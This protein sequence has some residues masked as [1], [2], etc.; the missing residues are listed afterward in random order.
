MVSLA[1][2]ELQTYVEKTT[3]A[4]LPIETAP[5]DAYPVTIYVGRSPSTDAMDLDD[6]D[7]D[8]GAFRS[9]IGPDFLVLF[10]RD[11]DY[12]P[13]E[14]WPQGGRSGW[15][16]AHEQWREITG[17]LWNTPMHD[18]RRFNA[19]LGIWIFDRGGSLNAVNEF[20]RSLGVRWYMPG[21]LGEVV[22]ETASIALPDIDET[23]RPD[24]PI[25]HWIHGAQFNRRPPEIILHERRQGVDALVKTLGPTV[26]TH[27]MRH[28]LGSDA[29]REAHPEY[30]AVII[31]EPFFGGQGHAC[32][33]SE[34]LLNE[35]VRYARTVFDHYD[36]PMLQLSPADGFRQCE[37]ESCAALSPS[38]LVFGFMNRVAREVY[39]T[40][41]DRIILAAGYTRYRDPPENIEQFSPNLAISINNVHR[42]RFN[43]PEH[44][45][46]YVDL[47]ESWKAKLAPGRLIRVENTLYGSEPFPV[48]HPRSIARDLREMKGTS[49]G[50]R[51]ELRVHRGD[52]AGTHLNLHV[53]GEK[54]TAENPWF[55]QVGRARFRG[56]ERAGSYGFAPT[57]GSYHVREDF[58]RLITE[59]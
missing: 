50:E 55:I 7:L 52:P 33:S 15:S 41:P 31:G 32:F 8:Y 6:S 57:G 35:T 14:P 20:L 48:F 24:Y 22:P 17:S 29:M 11:V 30:Y 2:Q 38:E 58:G 51:N 1:A 4:R 42:P 46:W 53:M 13:I 44:W 47:V 49:L 21:E 10:G 27:G 28:I 16:Q 36:V 34:G 12:E 25:R 45:Q 54:P 18:D 9:K 56:V 5:N 26:L 43:D 37:C 40:H 19:E 59:N 39:Q 23:V 3:G